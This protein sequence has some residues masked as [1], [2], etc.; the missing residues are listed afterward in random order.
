MQTAAKW[1]GAG[2]ATIVL[3]FATIIVGQTFAKWIK[4]PTRRA[5]RQTTP[6]INPYMRSSK[7]KK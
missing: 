4:G 7:V 2:Q 6:Y 1:I 5:S 3:G